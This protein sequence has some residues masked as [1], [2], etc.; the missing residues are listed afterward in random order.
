MKRL[1]AAIL[2]LTM[3]LSL[4]SCSSKDSQSGN[5]SAGNPSSA[6]STSVS[7][8]ESTW[9]PDGAVTIICPYGAG[10]ATDLSLRCMAEILSD[11]T[12]AS[13]TVMNRT[14]GGGTVGTTEF[15]L[16]E[17]D[18]YTLAMSCNTFFST[19]PFLNNIEYTLDDFIPFIG[20]CLEPNLLIVKGDSPYNTLQDLVDDFKNHPDKTLLY[21]HSGNGGIGHLTQAFFLNKAGI[22]NCESVPASSGAEGVTFVLGGH[23]TMATT[24]AVE[25]A[26]LLES[27]QVKPL[28]VIDSNRLPF[29]A[30]ADVPTMAECGYDVTLSIWKFMALPAGTPD[31][32]VNYWHDQIAKAYE[33]QRWLDFCDNYNLISNKE[34]TNETILEKL[35]PEIESTH[36]LLIDTGLAIK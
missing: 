17:P 33:D 34:M 3:M 9:K 10:G 8:S 12:G 1:N 30:Y 23:V 20:L 25:S 21:S 26:A 24:N 2:S 11:Q 27:G 35:I 18:G 22:D 5:V 19:Q 16:C 14:G 15:K 28:C 29:D 7:A 32:I 6:S 4:A 31:E 13:V 36:Q